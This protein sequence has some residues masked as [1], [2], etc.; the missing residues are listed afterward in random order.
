[1]AEGTT[2][3]EFTVQA[4]EAAQEALRQYT[5]TKLQG[6]ARD[7]TRS[8]EMAAKAALAK[9]SPV[10][11]AD[12]RSVESQLHLAGNPVA[13]T[14]AERRIRTISCREALER[15]THL[16]PTLRV[17]DIDPLISVRDGS[18]HYL[19]SNREALES[20]VVPFLA[21][22]QLL[23][24]QL[25]LSDED[26][27]GSYAA[28]VNS[29]RAKHSQAVDRKVASKIARAKHA[30]QERYGHFDATSL[31]LVL[32]TIQANIALDGYDEQ[33]TPCPACGTTAVISGQHEF[34]RWDVDFDE[35]GNAEG[36]T[37]VVT[38]WASEFKCPTC[39]LQLEFDE[40]SAAGLEIEL[41]VENADADDFID[42]DF[43]YDPGDWHDR[44]GP[45]DRYGPGDR[46]GPE[47][48]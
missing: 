14:K 11:I 12:P 36:A 26:V 23:Q 33:T 46:Y 6:F 8:V 37:P 31:K 34:Q 32:Q 2:S 48:R 38:L 13:R 9:V 35:E 27:F 44:Y 17:E 10:L 20:L 18:T 25:G 45:E 43:E 39:D 1:M 29:V 41:E 22:F 21:F 24:Q 40:L 4:V 15:M 19:V 7:A 47:N 3:E 30:F 16:V 5:E 42:P 28:L